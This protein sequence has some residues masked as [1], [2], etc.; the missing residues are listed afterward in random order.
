MKTKITVFYS[1]QSDIKSNKNL[2]QNCIDKALKKIK[3]EGKIQA[4][5][6]EINIDRDTKNKK[7]TPS[8][9]HTIFDKIKECDIFIADVTII[10]NN[11]FN[12]LTNNRLT[13]NPNVLIELGF[14][15]EVLGWE[16]IICLNDDNI[17]PIE[18]LP[19]DIRGHRITRFNSS[20]L[21]FKDELLQTLKFALGSIINDYDEI[22]ETR[23]KTSLVEHDKNIFFR[24]QEIFPEYLLK[25][26]LSTAAD[27]LFLTKY[28]Y[29]KWG[30]IESFRQSELNKFIEFK[31]QEAFNQFL[32]ELR[33]FESICSRNFFVNDKEYM[34]FLQ[35]KDLNPT[36]EK[37][38]DLMHS[39]SYKPEKAAGRNESWPEADKRISK[40]Q[41]QLYESS[42]RVLK[43]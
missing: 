23:K 12:R 20:T 15:I 6:L 17:S 33:K 24:I 34:E 22:L 2:I 30:Q 4:I 1:W 18:T 9:A 21:S 32:D 29:H 5:N 41:D 11:F 25:D 13:S 16:R 7:G 37:L 10:N 40:L 3:Q 38:E 42:D 35:Q 43:F 8:I 26:S 28:Y 19:F 31:V 27:S 39:V 36:P 14:A